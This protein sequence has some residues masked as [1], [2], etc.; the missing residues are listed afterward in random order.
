MSRNRI[1]MTVG[2]RDSDPIPKVPDAGEIRMENGQQVQIMHNGI[3][4]ISGGYHG[5][6]MSEIISR[7]A[8]H[9]EPQE[10]LVFHEI[11]KHVGTKATMVELGGFW[12][13][14]SLW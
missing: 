9:H 8:G 6:W 1:E 13:Y 11:L 10:E 2:C 12:S 7:L 14:Y 3:R 5:E 4:V